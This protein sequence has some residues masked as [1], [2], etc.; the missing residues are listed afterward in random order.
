MGGG[1]TLAVQQTLSQKEWRAHYARQIATPPPSISK[2][3]DV[4]TG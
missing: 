2:P 3:S 4:S 1:L